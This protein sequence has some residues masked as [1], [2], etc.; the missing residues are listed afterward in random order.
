MSDLELFR[1]LAKRVPLEPITDA[2]TYYAACEMQEELMGM[3]ETPV[4]LYLRML[5][6]L[7]ESYDTGYRADEEVS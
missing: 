1:G 3:K 4:V 2:E 6:Y 5:T 7:I